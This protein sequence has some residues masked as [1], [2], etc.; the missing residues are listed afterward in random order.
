[1]VA[2]ASKGGQ[3]GK[4]GED[5]D[6]TGSG[7]HHRAAMPPIRGKNVPFKGVGLL[8]KVMLQCSSLGCIGAAMDIPATIHSWRQAV[9]RSGACV[10]LVGVA[11]LSLVPGEMRPHTPASGNMD[12]LAA[13]LVCGA[14]VGLGIRRL[15]GWRM[16]LFLS[17]LAACFEVAQLLI[18]GR[19]P[20]LDNWAA[21]TA[22]A[23][24]AALVL[25]VLGMVTERR[26][27]LS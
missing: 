25:A 13:Y 7:R 1:V 2:A 19:N 3:G 14:L 10:A 6:G 4:T 20:G 22:G 18:P 16:P 9:L 27:R 21:S 26:H 11:V 15:N 12:H 23:V 8:R 24:I 17:A 5:G